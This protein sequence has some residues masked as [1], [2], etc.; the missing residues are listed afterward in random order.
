MLHR[1]AP[2]YAADSS[3]QIL[4]HRQ[5]TI[6][7]EIGSLPNTMLVQCPPYVNNGQIIIII[8][9]KGFKDTNHLFLLYVHGG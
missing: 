9:F 2:D 4:I 6:G 5:N 8:S 1:I 7:K 3:V